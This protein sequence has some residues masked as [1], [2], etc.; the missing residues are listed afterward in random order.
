MVRRGSDRSTGNLTAWVVALVVALIVLASVSPDAPNSIISCPGNDVDTRFD[1]RVDKTKLTIATYNVEWLFDGIDDDSI[2]MPWKDPSQASEHLARVG[3]VVAASQVDLMNV[4]E[5]EGCF[6]LRRICDTIGS[7][8][9]Y[10]PFLLAGSDSATRQQVGLLT[11]VS[12]LSGLQRSRERAST[13]IAGSRCRWPHHRSTSVSKHWYATFAVPGLDRELLVVGLHFKVHRPPLAYMH[14][15][16][17]S[18]CICSLTPARFAIPR[19]D[20]LIL[21]RVPSEKA[22]QK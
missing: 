20:L 12:P 19:Q 10:S 11:R 7:G 21:S 13:P 17:A 18:V 3:A 16:S 6:M 4:V 14:L 22:R 15:L 1:R 2:P 8:Y 5:I 9:G